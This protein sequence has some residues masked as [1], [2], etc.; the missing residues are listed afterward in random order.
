MEVSHA[1]VFCPRCSHKFKQEEKN[2]L[3]CS[4]CKY[5][6][7]ISP[8]PCN[9]AIIENE[10]GE[11]LLLKR[12]TDPQKGFCDLPGGFIEPGEDFISS[13][14]REIKEELNC[15]LD[16]KQ[17]IGA[18]TDIYV[19]Q[20]IALPTLGIVA[21]CSISSGDLKPADDTSEYHYVAK[22]EVL[23]QKIA[24]LSIKQA[25]RDYLDLE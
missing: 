9:A 6:Y 13:L 22:D 21:I 10:N 20:D 25:L 11:I 12:A 4:H 18:Y 17:I 1:Y 8:L 7:Y 16:V 3:V 5:N 15:E 2:L 19:Y 24:F 14:Q 23:S